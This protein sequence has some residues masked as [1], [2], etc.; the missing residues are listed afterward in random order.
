MFIAT[1]LHNRLRNP[2]SSK[3]FSKRTAGNF[4]TILS[5]IQ[6]RRFYVNLHSCFISFTTS[7][8]LHLFS[9]RSSHFAQLASFILH[10]RPSKHRSNSQPHPS[11]NFNSDRFYGLAGSRRS[12]P[13][14]PE[15]VSH[16]PSADRPRFL[17]KGREKG[18]RE[19]GSR[20]Y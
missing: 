11:E 2:H 14:S 16:E 7:S 17:R 5:F 13:A 10:G 9:I 8:R 20:G 19:R 3:R 18:E 12:L 6:F 4:P 15:S 1:R